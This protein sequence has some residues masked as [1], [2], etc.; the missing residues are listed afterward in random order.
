MST[1]Q[2]QIIMVLLLVVLVLIGAAVVYKAKS[3]P[4]AM[5]E[6]LQSKE[7]QNYEPTVI[8]ETSNNQL[9]TAQPENEANAST[10][11]TTSGATGTTSPATASSTKAT[12]TN[13][14]SI[15][16][17]SYEIL[18]PGT[19]AVAKAG[20]TVSVHYTG[21]FL[22]GKVFDSSVQRG[23]PFEF[24]LGA[25]MVI[26]GWDQGVEGMKVGEKRKLFIP[27]DLAYGAAGA[28]GAIP[29]NTPLVFEVELLGVK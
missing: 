5:D 7:R 8:S 15:T 13:P 11:S 26:K 28:P 23:Q 24:P 22:D 4:S 19:G 1:K 20:Q 27:S 9:M 6:N 16:K 10:Q 18:K 29:P 2:T 21:T 14:T 17:L 12:S 3:K 25:G